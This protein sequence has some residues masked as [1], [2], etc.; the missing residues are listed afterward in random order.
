MQAQTSASLL[1]LVVEL[2]LIH[3]MVL[4]VK[5]LSETRTLLLGLLHLDV[6]PHI[7]WEEIIVQILL[8]PL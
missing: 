5:L 2:T 8:P 1:A 6:V 3:M 7:L 4:L